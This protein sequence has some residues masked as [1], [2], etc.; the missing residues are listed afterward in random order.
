MQNEL[1]DN[2]KE[3]IKK[4]RDLESQMLNLINEFPKD[5]I[6]GRWS[7]IAKTHIQEGR[8]AAVRS[9]TEK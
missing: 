4:V 3:F 8:M 5:Q 6:D 7:S 9:V 1:T 2:V